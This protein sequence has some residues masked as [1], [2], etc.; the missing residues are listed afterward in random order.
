MQKNANDTAATGQIF[1]FYKIRLFLEMLVPTVFKFQASDLRGPVVP[2]S[3]YSTWKMARLHRKM[4]FG[5][6]KLVILALALTP[7]RHF[8]IRLIISTPAES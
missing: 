1:P 6:C 2:L 8:F 7:T 3:L 4:V 5:K